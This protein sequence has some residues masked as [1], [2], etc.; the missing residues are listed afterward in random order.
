MVL[1][2][3]AVISE[4][5][6]TVEK[7]PRQA[8]KEEDSSDFPLLCATAKDASALCAEHPGAFFVFQQRTAEF[9]AITAG[10]CH[11]MSARDG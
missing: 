1:A 4:W 5:D 10:N 2:A 11:L 8:V 3:C 7:F 6:E 9:G